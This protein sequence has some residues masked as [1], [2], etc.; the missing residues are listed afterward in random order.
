MFISTG[1]GNIE[2]I[3][4]AVN[5]AISSGCKDILCFIA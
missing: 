1:M 3:S 4:D 5:T 2:E